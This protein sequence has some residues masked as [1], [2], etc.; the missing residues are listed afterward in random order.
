MATKW[1]AVILLDEAEVF[2][3][4]RNPND[5]QRNELVS[6]FLREL[7]YFRGIV[8]LNT[9][10]YEDIDSVFRS[11]VSLYLLFNCLSKEA[12]ETV[13]RNFLQRLPLQTTPNGAG[14]LLNEDDIKELAMWQ[15]NGRGI[16]NAA[17]MERS[18]CN[19]TE[20]VVTLSSLENGIKITTPD[21]KKDADK[22]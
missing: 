8:F 17:K 2:M 14:K 15:L 20:Y 1:D 9:N 11:R 18:W 22:S 5:I 6:I 12:D 3:A 21:A 19:H 13:W 4:E 10:L 7:E 16:K